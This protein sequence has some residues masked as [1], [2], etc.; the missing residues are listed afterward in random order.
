MFFRRKKVKTDLAYRD[1]K[2]WWRKCTKGDKSYDAYAP[3]LPSLSEIKKATKETQISDDMIVFER[4]I[5]SVR[6]VASSVQVND[7]WYP[8]NCTTTLI[9]KSPK[10]GETREE[11]LEKIAEISSKSMQKT[12]NC[13]HSFSNLSIP[14]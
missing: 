12:K 1:L 11:V 3:Q 9:L 8:R 10:L 7:T 14:F 2:T 5:T 4:E 6:C 13:E